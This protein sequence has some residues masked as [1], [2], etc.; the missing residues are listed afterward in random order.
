MLVLQIGNE[1]LLDITRIR[2]TS[3]PEST[4]TSPETNNSD[5]KLAG[6]LH[7]S[8][9]TNTLWIAQLKHHAKRAGIIEKKKLLKA[10]SLERGNRDCL[11]Q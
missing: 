6:P 11:G 7:T 10:F 8:A 4:A 2:D 3:R 1:K 9:T 5:T